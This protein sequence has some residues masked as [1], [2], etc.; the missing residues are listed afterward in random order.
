MGWSSSPN[1]GTAKNACAV[2]K[3]A[4]MAPTQVG[5]GAV[6][7]K[8]LKALNFYACA[9]L[10]V[11]IFTAEP[12][13]NDPAVS[14]WFLQ[15]GM[16]GVNIQNEAHTFTDCCPASVCYKDELWIAVSETP[17]TYTPTATNLINSEQPLVPVDGEPK[18]GDVI[19][20]IE[21]APCT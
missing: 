4:T 20:E 17:T 13:A 5:T 1:P 3:V 21:Y 6:K 14:C 12:S 11:Q 8:S 10:Y 9:G 16:P 19:I 7:I 15:A 2:Q 18:D